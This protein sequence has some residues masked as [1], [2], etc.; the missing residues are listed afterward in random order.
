MLPQPRIEH[1]LQSV[2][3]RLN[4]RRLAQA[5]I[6]TLLVAGG[7]MLAVAVLYIAQGYA[8]PREWYAVS[9]V[10]GVVV[11]LVAW[12]LLREDSERSARFADRHFSLQDSLLSWLHFHKHH[13]TYGFY[14]LQA[15]QTAARL[16]KLQPASVDW[17]PPRR[18]TAIA[19]LLAIVAIGL[20]FKGPS[21]SVLDRLA[22]EKSTLAQTEQI[23][24]DLADLVDQLN[25][26]TEDEAERALLQPDKL[27]EM[28]EALKETTDQKEALKQYSKLEMQVQK[29]RAKLEQ[30]RDQKLMDDAAKE[31]ENDRETKALAQKLAEQ[32]YKEAAQELESFK[33]ES[34]KSLSEQQKQLAKLKAASQRMAAAV[35]NQRGKSSSSSM[36]RAQKGQSSTARSGGQN[37]KSGS[38]SGATGEAGGELGQ[39]IENLA[40]SVGELDKELAK[41]ARQEHEG[42]EI[43]PDLLAAIEA[44]Q[45]NVE[46][47]LSELSK[48]LTKMEI[49]LDA[50]EMLAQLCQACAA[51]Q[52]GL[53]QN[54]GAIG[55]GLEAGWGSNAFRTDNRE[56]LGD[57]GKT[58]AL[59]GIKGQGPSQTTVETADDGTGTSG[60]V[61]V[62]KKRNFERQFESFVS[63]EDVPAQVKSGVKN[64]FESIHQTEEQP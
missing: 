30:R 49:K 1:F 46:A 19:L 56:E 52:G 55:N 18:I 3:H 13:Q 32:K 44:E 39:A 22:Q 59:Q 27:K 8:V 12:L 17:R 7:A 37:G 9:A 43:D 33:P 61:G 57:N 20:G 5:C 62:A 29:A 23:N 4:L 53:C 25:A 36:S 58:T 10:A 2:R 28:I 51:C 48:H 47:Q 26:Q 40:N 54:P 15:E 64:Y 60:R 41:A 6:W 16:E 11:A 50:S 35:Q 45:L 42:G 31:L 14:A 63:R 34:T 24:K 38:A 21:Q